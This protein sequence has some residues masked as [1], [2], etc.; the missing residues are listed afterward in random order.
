MLTDHRTLYMARSTLDLAPDTVHQSVNCDAQMSS[1]IDPRSNPSPPYRGPERPLATDWA[2]LNGL[3]AACKQGRLY[4]IEAWIARGLPLQVAPDVRGRGTRLFSPLGIAIAA[5]HLDLI[6]LLLCN[7]YRTELEPSSSLDSVLAL[8]R[9]EMLD[10]LLAWG[11]DPKRVDVGRI[12]DTYQTE[13]FE[14]FWSAG[15]DLT[16]DDVMA[17]T[18]ASSTSN[19]PLYGFARAYGERDPRIARALAVGLGAA[20]K[21]KNDKA[22]NLCLWAGA[23]PRRRVGG[24]GE[25]PCED[26][27]GRTA[28]EQ[29][30]AADAPHYLK[31]LG[32]DLARDGLEHLYACVY[33]IDGLRALVAIAPPGD[34]QPIVERFIW[35]LDLSLRLSIRMT[36][37]WDI[38]EVFKLGARIESLDRRLKTDLRRLLLQLSEWDAQSLFRLLSNPQHMN[39]EAF[40]DLVGHEKLAARCWTW[41]QRH[42]V[43][44]RLFKQLG[45]T[46]SVPASVRRMA[47]ARNTRPK[48]IRTETTLRNPDEERTFSREELY[49]LVWSEPMFTL[50]KRFGLSDNGLRKRCTAAQVPTPPRGYWQALKSGRA[51]KRPPLPPLRGT[52]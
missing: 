50:C 39:R 24:V 35:R 20:I 29:A 4:D 30:V 27:H 51:R 18:L 14:R 37:L 44:R 52:A 1:Y 46:R 6:R 43:D 34:W 25:D 7:G 28:F 49:E 17:D 10:L 16:T 8:R 47:I 11:T 21:A 31:R 2:E 12:L 13:I 41:T 42:G 45:E 15:V 9:W 3:L 38:G 48:I 40:L 22:V 5:S 19:R 32:F 26:D 23:N 36:G 33:G